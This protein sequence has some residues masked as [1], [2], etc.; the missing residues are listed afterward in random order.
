[1]IIIICYLLMAIFTYGF[2]KGIF[3]QERE[4]GVACNYEE[5]C[6]FLAAFSPLGTIFVI[7]LFLLLK[8]VDPK[9]KFKLCF[10]MPQHLKALI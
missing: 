9:Y 8:F 2:A 4:R 10:R 1:M 5:L 7:F 6:V 3:K